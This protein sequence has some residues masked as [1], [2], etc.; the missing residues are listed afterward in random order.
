[1]TDRDGVLIL[2]GGLQSGSTTLVSYCFLQ[3][4]DT[5]GV[6][7]SDNNLLPALDYDRESSSANY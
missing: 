7:D 5:D 4:A 2:C 6:L 3:R 1:M